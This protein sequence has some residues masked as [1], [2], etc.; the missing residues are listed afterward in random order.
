MVTT[1]VI[2]LA[3]GCVVSADNP[4]KENSQSPENISRENAPPSP[5][6]AKE[7]LAS[8]TST[9]TI[10]GS[11]LQIE[12]NTLERLENNLLRLRISLINNSPE[13][14]DIGF[15]LAG[16]EDRRTASNISL[17]DDLNQQRYLSYDK[18]DGSCFCDT[19]EGAIE[20]GETETL[21]VIFPGAPENVESMTVTTPLTPPLLDIPVSNTSEAVESSNLGEPQ[22]LDLT[23]ISDSL[24]EDQT[25]RTE[26][27]DEVSIILSSD[28]LFSTNSS[29]LNDETQEIL[30]QVAQEIDDA[31]SSV[32]SIDGHADN[33]G[34]DSVNLPLSQDR[35]KSVE[36]TLGSLISREVTFDVEGHGSADPIA[37][38]TTEEGRK[39]NRRVSVT[40]EK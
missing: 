33:T 1:L 38:N 13:E 3:S 39:R 8:S 21:W 10:L 9:A 11:E 15:G 32:I 6:E 14:F 4:P 28:V 36:V 7:I 29:D 22:I 16:E 12:V 31:S 24:E 23:L 34:T 40:F 18:S 26:S 27:G 25:G 37:D 20:S 30:E 17:I 35:A 2:F 5:G 19:L